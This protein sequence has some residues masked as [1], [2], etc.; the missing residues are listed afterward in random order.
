MTITDTLAGALR[1]RRLEPA[2]HSA[3]IAAV[4]RQVQGGHHPAPPAPAPAPSDTQALVGGYVRAALIARYGS[5]GAIW[6]AGDFCHNY[7]A[8]AAMRY[9]TAAL[10]REFVSPEILEAC[11]VLEAWI[12]EQV[13]DLESLELAVELA[14]AGT[15]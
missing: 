2:E 8:L 7:D 10:R 11:A 6:S 3:M 5:Y 15:A 14:E 12:D 13:A 9:E 4:H 1:R